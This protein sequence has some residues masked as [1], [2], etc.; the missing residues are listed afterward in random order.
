MVRKRTYCANC[1][2]FAAGDPNGECKK[3]HW[4]IYM[5][6]AQRDKVCSYDSFKNRWLNGT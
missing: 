4:Q 6:L 1:S 3:Y 5:K 2:Q